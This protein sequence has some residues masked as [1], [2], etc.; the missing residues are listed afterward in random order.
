V[1]TPQETR[2]RIV[3]NG[4]VNSKR[5]LYEYTT[6]FPHGI[7]SFSTGMNCVRRRN[8]FLPEDGRM[9]ASRMFQQARQRIARRTRH[10]CNFTV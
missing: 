5:K 4:G 9:S 6:C 3:P 8:I 7:H 10:I 2:G 1:T